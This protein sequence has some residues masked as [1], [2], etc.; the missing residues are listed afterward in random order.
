MTTASPS[1]RIRKDT[2]RDDIRADQSFTLPITGGPNF[3]LNVQEGIGGGLLYNNVTQ[4]PYYNDGTQWLPL[5]GGGG[6]SVSPYALIKDGDMNVPTS[7]DTIITTWDSTPLPYNDDTGLWNLATGVYTADDDQ[8]LMVAANITWAENYSTIGRRFLQI[9]YKPSAG[10]PVIV[11]EAVTQP[12]PNVAI[13]TTQEATLVMKLTTGDQVWVQ[14]SQTS[15]VTI[16]ITGGNETS[17]SGFN[18]ST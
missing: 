7:T 4:L 3:P 2:R 18:S 15:G 17:L 9:I 11:K 14:V 10:A 12:D 5:G 16:P 6:S 1:F 13:K 8:S